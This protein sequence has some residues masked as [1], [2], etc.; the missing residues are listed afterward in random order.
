[1]Y[2]LIEI[3]DRV[4][5]FKLI[6]NTLCLWQSDKIIYHNSIIYNGDI[7]GCDNYRQS[8]VIPINSGMSSVY[9]NLNKKIKKYFSYIKGIKA[10][11]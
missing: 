4:N 6:E 9:L 5:D 10:L 3:I 11:L 2:K 8:F 1:M 7:F